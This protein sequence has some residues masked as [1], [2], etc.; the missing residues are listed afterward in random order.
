MIVNEDEARQVRAIVWLY[1]KN[2][3]SRLRN[4]QELEAAGWVNKRWTTRRKPA[5]SRLLFTKTSLHHLLTNVAYLSKVKYKSEVHAGGHWHCGARPLWQRVQTRLRQ[6]HIRGS[7]R[8]RPPSEPAPLQGLLPLRALQVARCAPSHTSHKA[9][10][11]SRYYTPAR[12]LK[13]G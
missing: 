6:N 11:V 10:K 5:V 1:L 12:A 2:A 4:V 8:P 9:L 13:L 7:S 3:E